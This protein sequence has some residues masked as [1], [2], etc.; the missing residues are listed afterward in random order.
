MHGHEEVPLDPD[1]TP[2]CSAGLRMHPTYQFAHTNGYR[3]QRFRCPL[4]FPSRTAETCPHQ[5]FAKGSG[6]VKDP[7]WEKGGLMRVEEPASE[8]ILSD[9]ATPSRCKVSS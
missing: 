1:G 6:C 4:L 2:R 9:A 5:Q 3:A 7:N 8:R